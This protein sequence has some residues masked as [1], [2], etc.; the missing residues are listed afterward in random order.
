MYSGVGIYDM[1]R[2]ERD[3]NGAFNV[4]EFGR[5]ATPSS[6]ARSSPTR[7]TTTSPTARPT[8]AMLLTTGEHDGRVNPAHSRKMT[9]RLQAASA[10]GRPVLLRVSSRAGDGMGSSRSEVVA[11]QTDVWALLFEQLGMRAP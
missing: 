11:E 7:P 3:P 9:A 6:F 4:A 8:P 1:L 5:C 10:P 2:V